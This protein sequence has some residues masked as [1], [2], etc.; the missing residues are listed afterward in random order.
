MKRRIFTFCMLLFLVS[1]ACYAGLSERIDSI[2]GGDSQN[3]VEFSINVIK[4]M[5]GKAVYSHQA[6]KALIP[7]SN[8]KIITTAAALR[9]LGADYEY[10][11]KVGLCDDTLVVIGGGDP[12]LGDEITDVKYEKEP[13]WIFE[14]II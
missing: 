3:G 7:A 12:L 1:G 13:G 6:G 14:E 10:V 4:A 2:I 8:M 5:S 11:T 9:F